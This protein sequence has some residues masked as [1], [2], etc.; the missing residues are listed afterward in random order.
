MKANH[1]SV[2]LPE[3]GALVKYEPL[4]DCPY[5]AFSEYEMQNIDGDYEL[6][7]LMVQFQNLIIEEAEQSGRDVREIYNRLE[8]E[9]QFYQDRHHVG[10][11]DQSP[12]EMMAEQEERKPLI[13][14]LI[15]LLDVI[16]K[17]AIKVAGES[18]QN[19]Y[20]IQEL[21]ERFF[22][23]KAQNNGNFSADDLMRYHDTRKK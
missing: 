12:V 13:D 5:D 18:N 17:R 1:F 9:V 11:M 21:K 16:H 10:I 14:K 6:S 7:K 2:T 20:A 4:I 3:L 23:W 22:K 15:Q 8:L 19:G